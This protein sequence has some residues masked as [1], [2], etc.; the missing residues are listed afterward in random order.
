MRHTPN[1]LLSG[2]PEDSSEC[3][4]LAISAAELLKITVGRV[5][6]NPKG[7]WFKSTACDQPLDFPR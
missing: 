2:R 7:R 3:P 4:N 1:R 6:H 5:T